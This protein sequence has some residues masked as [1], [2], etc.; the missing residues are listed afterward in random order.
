MS[1]S[2]RVIVWLSMVNPLTPAGARPGPSNWS[3]DTLIPPLHASLKDFVGLSAVR[4]A[5]NGSKTMKEMIIT[6]YFP[7]EEPPRP[8]F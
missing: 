6:D 1:R 7:L 5:Q 2:F 3:S 8:L 4:F